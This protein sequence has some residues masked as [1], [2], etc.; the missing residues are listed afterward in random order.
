MVPSAKKS[1]LSFHRKSKMAAGKTEV[2]IA[3]ERLEN[4]RCDLN[5]YTNIFDL[6]RLGYENDTADI[7]RHF[8]TSVA[9]GIQNGGHRHRKWK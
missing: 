9:Y 3:F 6:D 5:F 4:V 2:A 7:A 8:R 1:D